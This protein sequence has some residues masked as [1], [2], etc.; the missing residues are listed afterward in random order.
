MAKIINSDTR[1]IDCDWGQAQM[2]GI[3]N[4]GS[5]SMDSVTWSQNG[6]DQILE[7]IAATQVGAGSAV[8]F[9]KID[10][11]QMLK[12]NISMQ[13]VSVSVQRSSDVPLGGTLNGNNFDTVEEYLF[14]F[15]RPIE[16]D[17][18]FFGGM[19]EFRHIGLDR[20]QAVGT[21]GEV[22]WPSAEQCLFAE[23]T[24]YAVN[25]SLAATQTNGELVLGGANNSITGMPVVLSKNTWGS[26]TTI[27]GPTLY[28]YRVI[29]EYSQNFTG[30]PGF[31]QNELLGG[32]TTRQWPAVNVSFL[33]KDPN[34]T[35]GEYITKLANV[36]NNAPEGGP[37]A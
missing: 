20:N 26:L 13:P 28:C 5:R 24:S 17:M 7:S 16:W 11:S 34:F 3:R 21:A 31:L 27:T 19:T 15:T 9:Q 12:D 25:L 36:M 6:A 1:V 8:F 29:L 18:R 32:Q 23:K 33:C 35:E 2:Y 22:Y 10:L 4:P 37:V 14:V 30:V